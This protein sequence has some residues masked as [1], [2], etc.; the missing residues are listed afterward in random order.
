MSDLVVK[1][2]EFLKHSGRNPYLEGS[3]NSALEAKEI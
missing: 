1:D 3:E 2:Y